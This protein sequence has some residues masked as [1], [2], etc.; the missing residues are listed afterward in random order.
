M[1][2]RLLYIYGAGGHAKVVA[3]AAM[4]IGYT[5]LGFF[6][7]DLSKTNTALLGY[8]V[9]VMDERSAAVVCLERRAH[10]VIAIGSNSVRKRMF[11]TFQSAGVPIA[12]IVH[13]RAVVSPYAHVGEG[14]VVFAGAVINAAARVGRNVII[15]TIA[16]VGHDDIIGDHVHISSGVRIGGTAAVGEGTQISI[17]STIRNNTSVGAWSMVG[18][19]SVVVKDLPGHVVAYGVPARV[20]RPFSC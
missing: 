19:G 6:D 11:D 15:N 4:T 7:A 20:I 8:P 5:V 14:T 12:T 10:A 2:E 17:G 13:S 1:T 9:S 3:D 18:A 16:S